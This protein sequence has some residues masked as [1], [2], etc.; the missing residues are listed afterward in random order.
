MKYLLDYGHGG[1]DPGAIGV[2]N[3]KEKD[4]VLEIG[5]RVK[6]HLERHNQTVLESRTGDETVSLTERSNKANRNN[7]DLCISIHC[8]AFS[9][10]SAQ[11]VEIFYFQGSTRG[12]QLA[13]SILNEITKAKLYTKNRGLKT[14]NLHMT[15]ETSMPSV[16]IELGF[17][18]NVNDKNLIINNKENF[19]IAI[20]KGILSYYGITYKAETTQTT[21]TNKLYRVQVGAFSVKANA[22]K[23]ANELKQKG[24]DTIIV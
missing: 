3:V 12:Q 23:L 13:K 10:S 15:R 24:Y 4:I 9:D 8:N 22:E 2:D 7:V 11:G 20:T 21:T 18:T 1:N 19:A 17:I 6:Y 16:L 14:N 5:K